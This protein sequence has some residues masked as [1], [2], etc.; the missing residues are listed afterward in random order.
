MRRIWIGIGVLV[1]ILAISIATMIGLQKVHEPLAQNLEEAACETDWAKA[2]EI[3]QQA[4]Q[5]WRQYRHFTAA[6]ADHEEMDRIDGV[7]A[8]LEVCRR[9]GDAQ[10]HGVLCA[11][12]SAAVRAIQ[13][14]HGLTWWNLL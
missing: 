4:E 2:A 9:Q 1:A 12:L 8:Q 10:T 7:F 14:A 13:E 3:S 5:R 6:L 11:D